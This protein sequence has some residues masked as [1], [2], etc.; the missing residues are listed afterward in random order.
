[1]SGTREMG[2]KDGPT[3]DELQDD[4]MRFEG[5]FSSRL[6]GAFRPLVELPRVEVRLRAAQDELAFKS[7]ALDIAVG[8]SPEVDLLDMVTLVALGRDAMAR[9]WS[10]AEYG[11]AASGLPAAFQSSLDDI[12]E[13][14]RRVFPLEVEK[15]LRD[16]I[17]EWQRENLTR[18]DVAAVRLSAYAKFRATSTSKNAGIFSMIRGATQTADTAVLLGDRALY[19]TQRLPYLVRLHVRIAL[20]EFLVDGQRTARQVLARSAVPLLGLTL[21]GTGASLLVAGLLFRQLARR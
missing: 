3:R 21:A 6:T 17:A 4:L 19:A 7:S 11:E 13:I 20:R 5:R 16:V 8:S 12:A 14:A 10:E 2:S 9:R 15:E 18:D 1:M